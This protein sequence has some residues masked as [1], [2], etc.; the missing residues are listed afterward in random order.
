ML[1]DTYSFEITWGFS[2]LYSKCNWSSAW[3]DDKGDN[4]PDVNMTDLGFRDAISLKP[5]PALK[6]QNPSTLVVLSLTNTPDFF[7]LFTL[8]CS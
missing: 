2:I 6:H 4:V 1:I 7:F 5:I 8:N 3:K